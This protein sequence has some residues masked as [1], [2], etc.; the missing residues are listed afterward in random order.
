MFYKK[1]FTWAEVFKS[2][3]VVPSGSGYDISATN[4]N[5]TAK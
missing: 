5:P 4:S 1:I 2:P 3:H